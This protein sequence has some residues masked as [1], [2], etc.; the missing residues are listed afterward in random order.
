MEKE[1][2]RK[3][4]TEGLE[5]LEQRVARRRARFEAS[6]AKYGFLKNTV[7]TAKVYAGL[8]SP[9]NK[10]NFTATPEIEKSLKNAKTAKQTYKK[11]KR[12]PEKLKKLKNEVTEKINN[13]TNSLKDLRDRLTRTINPTDRASILGE[14]QILQRT[15]QKYERV[16]IRIGKFLEGKRFYFQKILNANSEI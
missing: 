8:T 9:Y 5:A 10:A 14:M 7:K 11:S 15:I 16:K 13:K 3:L 12:N 6:Q 1:K 4:E 2:S